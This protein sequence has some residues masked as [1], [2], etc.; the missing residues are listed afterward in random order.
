MNLIFE[1]GDRNA[2]VGHALL[3]FLNGPASVYACYVIVPP[4]GFDPTEFTPPA[5]APLL[6]GLDLGQMTMATPMPPIP[7]EVQSV[8]YLRALAGRRGDDLIFGGSIV[9]Q[10]PAMLIPSVGEAAG[11]YGELYQASTLPD[12]SVPLPPALVPDRY[13][14]MSESDRINELTALT[15]RLRDS[16]RNGRVDTSLLDEMRDLTASLPAK[17]R[18]SQII[19]A[20]QEPGERGQHLAQLYLERCFKLLQED[21]LDL[22]RIDREI[23]AAGS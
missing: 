4:I 3:Y 1:R 11:A 9:V 13:E 14:G 10:S 20:A 6:Q 16:V 23:D 8:D 2:P 5:L 7:Q 12:A 22:E 18:G 19:K 17:Y 21:Y 15:G